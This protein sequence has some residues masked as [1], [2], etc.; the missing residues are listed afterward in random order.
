MTKNPSIVDLVN[1]NIT[2]IKKEGV[3]HLYTEEQI[4]N[5]TCISINGK[6]VNHFGSCSYL[7]LETDQRL[8]DSAIDAINKYGIQ[9]SCS[10]AYLAVPLYRE[11]ESLLT[12]IFKN[13]TLLTPTS[14][15]GH[16]A[17]I[18]ILAG[19]K[20]AIVLD[21]Q[22]H[23]SV[24]NAAKI[25]NANGAHLEIVRHSNLE[26]LERRI[27][28]LSEKHKAIW[29]MADG[30][31]SMYGDPCPVKELVELLDKYPKLH[32]YIDDAHG[33][34]WA[35]KNGAGYILNQVKLHPRMVLVT[36]LCK[37]FGASG[38]ATVLPNKQL[39]E[40]IRNCGSTHIFSSPLQ[41]GILGAAIA[42]AKIHLSPELDMLQS[43]LESNI[44]YF[45]R[46]AKHFDLPLIDFSP[47]PIQYIGT[48]KPE[49]TLKICKKLLAEGYYTCVAGYPS[50]P[51]NNCGLRITINRLHSKQ[52][53]LGLLATLSKIMEEVLVDADYSKE[54]IL[55][56]FKTKNKKNITPKAPH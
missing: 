39:A 17:N 35:E 31:Y 8:K 42:S 47:T 53:I 51:Y 52:Q 25:A 16:L 37:G 14:T 1:Q 10:R 11:L 50:V 46:K 41:P 7:N 54:D 49:I 3:G 44:R 15:L 4:L 56:A 40:R 45:Q 21:H 12:K 33:M 24:Q 22:V 32:L 27:I 30:I 48:G 34:S 9:F 38:G 43:R 18:P 26:Y 13:P 28:K 23:N 6:S 36:S 29:Y 19:K 2:S 5:G 55:K 20:D